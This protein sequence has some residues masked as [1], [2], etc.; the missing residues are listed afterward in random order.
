MLAV[1]RLTLFSAGANS[2]VICCHHEETCAAR[3]RKGLLKG[4]QQNNRKQA[5]LREA[6]LKVRREFPLEIPFRN[7]EKKCW[8]I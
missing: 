3:M 6:P 8:N 4:N 2:A 7:L 1:S 5:M